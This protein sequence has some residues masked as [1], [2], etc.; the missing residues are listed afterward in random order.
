MTT[1][2]KS[3]TS[4]DYDN[5]PSAAAAVICVGGAKRSSEGKLIGKQ[6]PRTSSYDGDV[7]IAE[8]PSSRGG[9]GRSSGSAGGGGGGNGSGSQLDPE[10]EINRNRDFYRSQDVRPPFTYAALIRQGIIESPERQ[11]TLN[12]IYTWFQNTFAYFRRNAATWK[13]AV[14]HN[15]SLHKCFMRVENVKGA[16]WTVDEVEYHR[17][18]PQR[19]TGSTSGNGSNLKQ[20]DRGG[21]RP[22]SPMGGVDPGAIAGG[23]GGGGVVDPYQQAA[24][25]AA[26]AAGLSMHLNPAMSA[27]AAAA[28]AAH[29]SSLSR[30]SVEQQVY[31]RGLGALPRL[32]ARPL[33]HSATSMVHHHM[34]DNKMDFDSKSESVY[35]EMEHSGMNGGVGG[36]EGGG[37]VRMATSISP[38]PTAS[39]NA[40]P[41]HRPTSHS[42]PFAADSLETEII[43]SKDDVI[44]TS[45]A[46]AAVREPREDCPEDLSSNCKQHSRQESQLRQHHRFQPYL[47]PCSPPQQSAM[48]A[49]AAAAHS[50]SP[51]P[52]TVQARQSQA[53]TPPPPPSPATAAAGPDPS[54]VNSQ[55]LSQ[56][57]HTTSST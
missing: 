32:T 18:R 23:G 6:I 20:S 56:Q 51:S 26:A 57:R 47:A 9:G 13:N 22:E 5:S 42:P 30:L 14:R 11:L 3:V 2:A 46:A 38:C 35:D 21:S 28:A 17:R 53:P 36:G 12:E 55:Q 44:M 48:A 33:P 27:A 52:P 31:F 1:S 25:A 54:T 45:S 4:A 40:T 50:P 43:E 41:T 24:V 49:A 34:F 10:C 7:I 19:G 39:S 15:L 16:V 29:S 37:G 8:P